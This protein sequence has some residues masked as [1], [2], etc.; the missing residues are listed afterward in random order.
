MEISPPTPPAKVVLTPDMSEF[1]DIWT[2]AGVPDPLMK[3]LGLTCS[4]GC[5]KTF[6]DYVIREDMEAEW[7]EVVATAFPSLLISQWKSR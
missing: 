1:I 7:K 5:V 3:Y 2:E 6:L 4:I